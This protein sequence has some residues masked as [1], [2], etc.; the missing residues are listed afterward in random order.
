M[1]FL[2]I[3]QE[4]IETAA[5]FDGS[6]NVVTVQAIDEKMDKAWP[7]EYFN[8]SSPRELNNFEAEI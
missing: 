1:R 4:G 6:R 3:E 5:V 7:T 2:T 8:F